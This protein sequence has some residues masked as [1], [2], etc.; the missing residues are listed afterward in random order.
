MC[1][2]LILSFF[3]LFSPTDVDPG[4]GTRIKMWPCVPLS[5]HQIKGLSVTISLSLFF[6]CFVFSFSLCLF[7]FFLQKR[8]SLG[9]RS[10]NGSL[11]VKLHKIRAISTILFSNFCYDV[12][13][14]SKIDDFAGKFW[15]KKAKLGVIGCKVVKKTGG[16]RWQAD[17]K[18]GVYWQVDNVYRLMCPPTGDVALKI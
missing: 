1:S 17:G 12:Q 10:E 7:F 14:F 15:S 11:G 8:D 6:S 18:K 13:N 3:F 2:I 16:I 9:D 5:T 4:E